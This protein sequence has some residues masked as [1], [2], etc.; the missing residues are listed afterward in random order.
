MFFPNIAASIKIG[1]FSLFKLSKALI[2][3]IL[4][5][6]L[7]IFNFCLKVLANRFIF[8]KIFSIILK[9]LSRFSIELFFKMQ[10]KVMF[11][12]YLASNIFLVSFIGLKDIRDK[13]ILKCI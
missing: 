12:Y 7:L 9:E 3:T 4:E 6:C 10:F 2:T 5:F 8:F 1:N 13:K 11:Y